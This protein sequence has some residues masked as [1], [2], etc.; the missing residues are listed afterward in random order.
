MFQQVI[1]T[2]QALP[3]AKGSRKLQF[4]RVLHVLDK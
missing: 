1:L 3:D 2:P 4:L